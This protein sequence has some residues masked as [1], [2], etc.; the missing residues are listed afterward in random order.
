MIWLMQVNGYEQAYESKTGIVH[1]SHGE[2][3]CLMWKE[4]GYVNRRKKVVP[5][6]RKM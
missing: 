6:F 5:K 2:Y 1:G 3:E 4:V